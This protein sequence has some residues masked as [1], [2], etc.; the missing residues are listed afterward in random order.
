MNAQRLDSRSI[1]AVDIYCT[2]AAESGGTSEIIVSCCEESTTCW[3]AVERAGRE[4]IESLAGPQ[5]GEVVDGEGNL[6]EARPVVADGLLLK[7]KSLRLTSA[8]LSALSKVIA[9]AE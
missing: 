9:G 8:F 2:P 6:R 1:L 3:L 5:R 7:I 4:M